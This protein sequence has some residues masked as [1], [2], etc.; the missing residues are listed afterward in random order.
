[1]LSYI[2]SIRNECYYFVINTSDFLYFLYLFLQIKRQINSI[3]IDYNNLVDSTI[4]LMYLC[5]V[6]IIL[7]FYT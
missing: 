6:Y 3:K 4:S 7:V 5:S 2:S 1:M